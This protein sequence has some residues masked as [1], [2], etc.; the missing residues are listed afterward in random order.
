MVRILN[1]K[2]LLDEVEYALLLLNSVPPSHQEINHEVEHKF[3]EASQY[4]ILE[5]DLANHFESCLVGLH[6]LEESLLELGLFLPFLEWL[7][8]AHCFVYNIEK[9]QH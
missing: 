7:Q 1:I 3:V 9:Y 8:Q 5:E 2:L 6:L 4:I